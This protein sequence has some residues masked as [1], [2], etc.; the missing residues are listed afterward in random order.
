VEIERDTAGD[1]IVVDDLTPDDAPACARLEAE[2]FGGDDPW[3]AAAFRAELYAGYPYLAARWAGRPRE[4]RAGDLVGYAGIALLPAPSFS[5]EPAEAEV[6]TIGVDP[7]VQGHGVGRRLL[8]GL[9]DR[10]D[11]IGAVTFLE[12]RTDNVPALAL[13]SSEGFE[14]VGTRRRYYASGADAHTMRRAARPRR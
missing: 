3:T 12:V 14:V 10:A 13:Y 9:L 7:S 8:L 6:H 2:L 4:E 5:R 1:R 11:A